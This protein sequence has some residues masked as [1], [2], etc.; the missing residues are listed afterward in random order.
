MKPYTIINGDCLNVL[1]KFQN[2]SIDMIFTSPPYAE[3]RKKYYNSIHIDNYIKWFLPIAKELKRVLKNTGSFFLNIKPHVKNG[4]RVLYVYKLVIDIVEKI[5]FKFADEF[6]WTKTG[7]PG[8]YHGRFK[9]EF[10]PIYHFYKDKLNNITFNAYACGKPLSESTVKSFKLR[11]YHGNNVFSAMKEK[12]IQNIKKLGLARPSN[13]IFI[14]NTHNKEIYHPA[15]F[16]EKLP[17]FFIKSFSNENDIILDPFSGSATTGIASIK[18]NRKYIG[19][20]YKK[21]YCEKSLL[22]LNNFYK[23][24]KEG[25]TK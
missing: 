2:D 24:I 4:E 13:V 20:D 7:V 19:I 17:E 23:E 12:G 22:R 9:N 16:P 15:V 10:E 18:N 11:K 6:C 21:E 8:S 25:I 5:G 1:K 14:A 3:L